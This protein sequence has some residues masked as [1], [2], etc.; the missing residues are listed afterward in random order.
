[1]KAHGTNA[2]QR[3]KRSLLASSVDTRWLP[4]HCERDASFQPW[5]KRITNLKDTHSW[6]YDNASIYTIMRLPS[7]KEK[8][9]KKQI[10]DG[11]EGEVEVDEPLKRLFPFPAQHDRDLVV[12]IPSHELSSL[13]THDPL[14]LVTHRSVYTSGSNFLSYS[15]TTVCDDGNRP[16][17][18]AS[19]RAAPAK[20][21]SG[22]YIRVH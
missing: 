12:T 18:P 3:S 19:Y 10:V 15:R 11:V 21:V 14:T 4:A 1:M 5:I 9:M 13:L 2:G 17:R 22:R 7:K 16:E 8:W 6:S 20:S